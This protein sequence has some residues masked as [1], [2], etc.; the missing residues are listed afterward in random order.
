MFWNFLIWSNTIS[1]LVFRC[2]NWPPFTSPVWGCDM[3][4]GATAVSLDSSLSYPDGNTRCEELCLRRMASD[5]D[6][7][8]CCFLHKPGGRGCFWIARSTADPGIGGNGISI[9]CRLGKIKLEMFW[10]ITIIFK[11][12]LRQ[13]CNYLFF[14]NFLD[15]NKSDRQISDRSGLA[16]STS[17]IQLLDKK[18]P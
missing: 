15:E 2:G 8:G 17:Q 13:A 9:S 12:I 1:L 5:Q 7:Y 16:N 3:S 18:I 10:L 11:L 4:G 14:T 6:K